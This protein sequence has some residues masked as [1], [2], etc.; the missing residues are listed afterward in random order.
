MA[1]SLSERI[2]ARAAKK[3]ARNKANRAAFLAVR[4]DVKAALAD[5]WPVKTV[6]ETLNEEGKIEFS[7][8]AF[9]GYVNRL[10][11]G[12]PP[13]ATSPPPPQEP[14]RGSSPSPAPTR[15][16]AKPPAKAAGFEFNPKPNKEDLL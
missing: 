9:R 10:V 1:K 5:G 2:A 15:R 7:Y 13:P 14:S 11:L 12:S 8:Q 6:W 4:D 16:Q 3:P